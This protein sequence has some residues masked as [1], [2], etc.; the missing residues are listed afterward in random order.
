MALHRYG[1]K[2]GRIHIINILMWY[3]IMTHSLWQTAT[4][5]MSKPI[6]RIIFVQVKSLLHCSHSRPPLL[7]V[8]SERI[9]KLT[10]LNRPKKKRNKSDDWK[11][12][13]YFV[14][15]D[16]HLLAC[17]IESVFVWMLTPHYI[18]HGSLLV[19]AFTRSYLWSCL[20]M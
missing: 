5:F 8:F 15:E 19:V 7:L 16:V 17:L 20:M 2:H 18:Q 3:F 4:K 1:T 11:F 12:H 9:R 14:E 10:F 13:I 6:K